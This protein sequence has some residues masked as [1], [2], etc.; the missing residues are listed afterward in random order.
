MSLTNN[1]SFTGFALIRSN[2]P[3][4]RAIV[5]RSLVLFNIV[6]ILSLQTDLTNSLLLRDRTVYRSVSVLSY[7]TCKVVYCIPK[8]MWT[9]WV[10]SGYSQFIGTRVTFPVQSLDR[11]LIITPG[12]D[13]TRLGS[14]KIWGQRWEVSRDIIPT[15]PGFTINTPQFLCLRFLW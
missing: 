7:G 10:Y 11:R 8:K 12:H 3:V 1:M 4:A 15:M 2:P 5:S 13:A 14:V 9:R 6:T